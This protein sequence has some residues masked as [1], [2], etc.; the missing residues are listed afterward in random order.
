MRYRLANC[1]ANTPAR[2]ELPRV[3]RGGPSQ[4]GFVSSQRLFNVRDVRPL[5]IVPVVTISAQIRRLESAAIEAGDSLDDYAEEWEVESHDTVIEYLGADWSGAATPDAFEVRPLAGA[6]AAL[7]D[8][9]IVT[10]PP[11]IVAGGDDSGTAL[12]LDLYGNSGTYDFV[13]AVEGERGGRPFLSRNMSVPQFRLIRSGG[14]LVGRSRGSA[15][16]GA[17]RQASGRGVFV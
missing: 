3:N 5:S 1:D 8:W 12:Y 9:E 15:G 2:P 14:A 10:R 4:I 6:P 13:E 17:L 7:Q 16:Q 11:E